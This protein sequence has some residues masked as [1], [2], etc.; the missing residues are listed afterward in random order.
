MMV[1]STVKADNVFIGTWDKLLEGMPMIEVL[2]AVARESSPF[3]VA[4][5][6]MYLS[7]Q[8]RCISLSGQMAVSGLMGQ[9]Q[10]S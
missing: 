1:L 8:C 4:L 3:C 7:V 6:P 10:S 2:V 5:H 9:I